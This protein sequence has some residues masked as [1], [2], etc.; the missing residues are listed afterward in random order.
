M[1][2][3][4][5]LVKLNQPMLVLSLDLMNSGSIVNKLVKGS[6]FEGDNLVGDDVL[7]S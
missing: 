5:L 4:F 3:A 1:L 7:L 2:L 6:D